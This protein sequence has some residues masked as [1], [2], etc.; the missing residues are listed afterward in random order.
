MKCIRILSS[1]EIAFKRNSSSVE[2]ENS[3]RLAEM[4]RIFNSQLIY[5]RVFEFSN[6]LLDVWMALGRDSY[7]NKKL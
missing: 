1:V 2:I 7:F 4:F 5:L 6:S 3:F